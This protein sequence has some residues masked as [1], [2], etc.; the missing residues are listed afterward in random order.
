MLTRKTSGQIWCYFEE[1]LMN[2][3]EEEK[4]K[5]ESMKKAN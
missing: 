3:V 4:I 1:S 2:G 5:G